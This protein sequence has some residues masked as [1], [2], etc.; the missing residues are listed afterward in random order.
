MKMAGWISFILLATAS[1][2]AI[3]ESRVIPDKPSKS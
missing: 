3:A 2:I 1:M